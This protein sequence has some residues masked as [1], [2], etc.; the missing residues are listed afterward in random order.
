[1]TQQPENRP[2]VL[3]I[4][5]HPGHELFLFQLFSEFDTEINCFTD[6][7]GG[8]KEDRTAWTRDVITKFGGT[9][10]CVFGESTDKQL[11]AN[12]LGDRNR[13]DR[14]L[15]QKNHESCTFFPT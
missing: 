14:G 13:I 15:D 12:I 6:G 7:S 10:G 3:A 8:R 5:G 9:I 2:R 4:F 11:Y 1:M